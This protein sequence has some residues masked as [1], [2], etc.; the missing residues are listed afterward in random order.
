[1]SRVKIKKLYTGVQNFSPSYSEKLCTPNNYITQKI[2][3]RK[4]KN[5][6]SRLES[7]ERVNTGDHPKSPNLFLG[8]A[9]E[10]KSENAGVGFV[11]VDILLCKNGKVN[12]KPIFHF[13]KKKGKK[14][15]K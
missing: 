13:F 10:E 9:K 6:I 11:L 15:Q 12:A 3:K 4:R 2:K 8:V 5:R 1:M 7:G 14:W